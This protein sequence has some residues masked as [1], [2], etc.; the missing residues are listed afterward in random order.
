MKRQSFVSAVAA[1]LAYM[2]FREVVHVGAADAA[3]G[4]IT[5]PMTEAEK[6][7]FIAIA[8]AKGAKISF[9][10]VKRTSSAENV[11]LDIN[12]VNASIDN[13]AA[14]AKRAGYDRLAGKLQ[15]LRERGSAAQKT[16]FV[17]GSGKYYF[18]E[19]VQ[20]GLAKAEL[21]SHSYTCVGVCFIVCVCKGGGIQECAEHCVD[22][23]GENP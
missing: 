11:H 2:A 1:P 10:G 5:G 8:K 4:T 7:P 15:R 22:K 14:R 21:S 3:T 18:P 19:D 23:C 12:M 17:M 16:D 20:Q 6:Q 9:D 13:A